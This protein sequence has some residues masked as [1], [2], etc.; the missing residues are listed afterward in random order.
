[1]SA[2]AA[3]TPGTTR[4]LLEELGHHP[5]KRLGQNF[6]ID[7]NIVRKSVSLAEL[8]PG[9]AVVE[10]G[11]GLGTLTGALLEA[12]AQVFAVELDARLAEHLR[13]TFGDAIDLLEGDAVDAPIGN[14]PLSTGNAFSIISNLPYAI[15]SPWLEAVLAGPLPR[16]MVLMMQRE[17]A[18]RLTAASGSGAFGAVSIFLQSAFLAEGR[19]FISRSCFYPVPGVDSVLLVL[20]RR[21]E[22]IRYSPEVR[23]AIRR[24]F[25][26]RRKQLRALLRTEPILESWWE[27]LDPKFSLSPTVRAEA[28]PLEAWHLLGKREPN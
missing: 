9:E 22:P 11:P 26:H 4:T 12:G 28:V 25:T 19:H 24:V 10:V 3:L 7:G 23:S 16:R 8:N 2:L 5:R 13:Q 20:A 14:L 21:P 15:T 18:D 1:M 27:H 6:L 17:A